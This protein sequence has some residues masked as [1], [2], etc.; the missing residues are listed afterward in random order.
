MSHKDCSVL[1]ISANFYG[2]INELS[3]KTVQETLTSAGI[4]FDHVSVPGVFEIANAMNIIL[5][6]TNYDGVIVL[7]CVIRGET[8]SFELLCRE[9]ARSINDMALHYSIPLGFGIITAD[10]IKQ[11]QSRAETY[12][13]K[14][15]VACMQLMG[16]K[17]EFDNSS[18][19]RN[20]EYNS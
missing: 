20:Y 17:S 3:L 10:N 9:S 1:I 15:S 18:D 11:A 16:I 19:L 5:E 7:G 8:F 6:Y 4:T 12:A 13:K 2:E 14:A